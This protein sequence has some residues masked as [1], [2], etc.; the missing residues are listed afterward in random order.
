MYKLITFD[1]YSAILDINGS[2]VPI[3]RE[4]LGKS[5]DFSREF[6]ILWRAQQWNYLLLNNSM[7][8]GFKSYRYI[9]ETVLDYTAKKFNVSLSSEMKDRLMQVWT[10]FK[11]WPEVIEVLTEIKRRGYK[12]GMLSNGDQEMLAPLAGSCGIDFD[13]IFSADE[14][15]Y[16]KPNPNVYSIPLKRLDIDKNKMLHVA[17]SVFDVMGT[18][19]AG[20]QCAW[21]NRFRDYVLDHRYSPDYDMK[22][23]H[24]LLTIL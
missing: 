19:S 22:D 4:A 1:M 17:G 10:N 14:A 12:I 15:G 6:F 20:F 16:Y 5:E 23:L 7:E 21:S 9:T 3:I 18:K 8:K 13:Y 2:A 11:P 24:D